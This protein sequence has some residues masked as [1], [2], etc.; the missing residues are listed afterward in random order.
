M[1]HSRIFQISR[2]KIEKEDL[3]TKECYY[4]WD[5][6]IGDYYSDSTDRNHDIEWLQRMLDDSAEVSNDTIT[7][8][9]VKEYFE[10]KFSR[11]MDYIRTI[12]LDWTVEDFMNGSLV[13]ETIHKLQN[14][15]DNSNGFWMDC[16]E[17]G[18]ITLDKFMRSVKP[19]E[20]YYIGSIIEYHF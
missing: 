10:E 7:I 19:G 17:M 13:S 14:E 12:D 11:F 1:S 15:V 8:T 20:I 16:S 5:V 6:G 9:D 4:T 2:E 3:Y 18:L